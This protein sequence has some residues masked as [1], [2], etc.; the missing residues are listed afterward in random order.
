MKTVFSLL[1]LHPA[2]ASFF[3]RRHAFSQLLIHTHTHSFSRCLL[4]LY[5]VAFF[6]NL[7]ITN[8]NY[9]ERLNLLIFYA[10][11]CFHLACLYA[12]CTIVYFVC[13]LGE[14][15]K[16]IVR[17]KFPLVSLSP[18]TTKTMRRR[19]K[20]IE[21]QL[22][23]NGSYICNLF[24]VTN[25]NG[26]MTLMK[27]CCFLFTNT[28]K[29]HASIILCALFLFPLTVCHSFS[30]SVH[31]SPTSVSTTNKKKI[32]ANKTTFFVCT[33]M[34]HI[35]RFVVRLVKSYYITVTSSIYQIF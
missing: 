34:Y 16:K 21:F 26:F 28:G 12:L 2:P 1:Y 5:R 4:L 25:T 7:A 8:E 19:T 17:K 24:D 32:V 15:K 10:T 23:W 13:I 14:T 22:S 18:L 29:I 20:T 6:F 31:E 9:A 33:C 27:N 35:F 11:S 30:R 3:F